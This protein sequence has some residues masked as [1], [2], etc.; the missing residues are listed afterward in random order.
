[1]KFEVLKAM[2]QAY[3]EKEKE[4]PVLPAT[5]ETMTWAYEQIC[6]GEDPWTALGNFTNAWYGYAKH[7]RTDLINKPLARPGNETEY[8]R[9]WGAFCAASV[10]FLCNLYQHY[11]PM[12]A[13]DSYYILEVP[14]WYIKQ[15]DDPTTQE[16]I[17]QTTP[18]PFL[19]RNIFCG[20]RLFQ[21]NMRCMNG[22]GKP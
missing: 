9:R 16:R 11:C 12:W 22:F 20:N 19:Q 18:V 15:A 17:L 21:I 7:I 8:T 3:K 6:K 2:A 4:P 13:Y 5:I 10:E 14:W 1:M